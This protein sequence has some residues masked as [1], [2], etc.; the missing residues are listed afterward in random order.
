MSRLDR[1]QQDVLA[2]FFEHETR[3]HVPQ[4][5]PEKPL[6]G[7]IRIDPPE[8]ILVN[9]L[10]TLL[11]RAEIRDLVDVRELDRAGYLIEEHLTLAER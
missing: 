9:K 1:F 7:T 5:F 8:E 6:I 3:D 4:V 10:C 2:A 11:S